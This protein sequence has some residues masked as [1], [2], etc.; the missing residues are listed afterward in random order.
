[1]LS[2]MQAESTNSVTTETFP[3]IIS[4]VGHLP[5]DDLHNQVAR[6]Q[7]LPFTSHVMIL[8]N[9][10]LSNNAMGCDDVGGRVQKM[11]NSIVNARELRFSCTNP[12][13]C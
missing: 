12:S 8:E 11:C 7:R 13:M 9:T 6:T 1:M 2:M 5:L 3:I 10:S 4:L